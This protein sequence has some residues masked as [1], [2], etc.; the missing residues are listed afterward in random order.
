MLSYAPFFGTTLWTY[1]FAFNVE[2]QSEEQKCTGAKCWRTTF[3]IGSAA[4]L[5]AALSLS[6]LWRRWQATV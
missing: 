6:G 3:Q 5:V 4:V 1:L 2:R